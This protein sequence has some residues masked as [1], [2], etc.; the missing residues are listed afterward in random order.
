MAHGDVHT[1][2]VIHK[3]QKAHHIVKI[4][5]RLTD[6]HQHNVRDGKAGFHLGKEHLVQHFIGFQTAH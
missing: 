4:I 6:T 2:G 5:Q 3:L 1:V